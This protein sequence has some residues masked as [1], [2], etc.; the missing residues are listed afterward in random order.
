MSNFGKKMRLKEKAEEDMYFAKRDRELIRA[1][2]EKKSV[3]SP[4]DNADEKDIKSGELEE[5]TIVETT[6]RWYD[7]GVIVRHLRQLTRKVLRR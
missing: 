2:H 7:P 1:S 3:A 6:A 5:D 4:K